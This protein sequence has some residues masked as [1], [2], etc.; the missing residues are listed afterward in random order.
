MKETPNRIEAIFARVRPTQK[1]LVVLAARQKGITISEL[2]R[3]AV[4][5]KVTKIL[6]PR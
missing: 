3:L 2:V 5:D 1:D 6:T 4:M